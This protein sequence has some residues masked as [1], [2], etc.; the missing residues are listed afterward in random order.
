M[1]RALSGAAKGGA[2]ISA[3]HKKT[4]TLKLGLTALEKKWGRTDSLGELLEK[5]C[6]VIDGREVE[7]GDEVR[8]L[9]T[10]HDWLAR[11]AIEAVAAEIIRRGSYRSPLKVRFVSDDETNPFPPVDGGF[12][13]N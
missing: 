7:F 6:R 11:R 2:T 10:S 8:S 1:V 12:G 13:R 3:A 9:L 4:L 5:A